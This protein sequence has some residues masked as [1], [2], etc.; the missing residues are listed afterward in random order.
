[1]PSLSLMQVSILGVLEN[2]T[3]QSL[4]DPTGQSLEDPSGYYHQDPTGLYLFDPTGHYSRPYGARFLWPCGEILF[5]WKGQPLRGKT[6]RSSLCLFGD[7]CTKHVCGSR[8]E[9]EPLPGLEGGVFIL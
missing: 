4:E 6:L 9:G 3:G 1:M 7:I 5:W 2:P 8:W